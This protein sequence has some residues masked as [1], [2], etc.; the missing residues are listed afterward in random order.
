MRA[1]TRSSVNLALMSK[2]R[3]DVT[4]RGKHPR[5]GP[6]DR[7]TSTGPRTASQRPAPHASPPTG[8][9]ASCFPK[10]PRYR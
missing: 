1:S 9:A 5:S 10:C 3:F 4:G 6:A 8:V 7:S 2:S